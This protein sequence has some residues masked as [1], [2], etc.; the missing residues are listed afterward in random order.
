MRLIFK[1]LLFPLMLKQ[2]LLRPVSKNL[3][4]WRTRFEMP[5]TFS[6]VVERLF[7]FAFRQHGIYR[8]LEGIF[9]FVVTHCKT[10]SLGQFSVLRLEESLCHSFDHVLQLPLL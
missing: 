2:T 3:G 6:E 9:E 7:H 5:I 4:Q 1:A 8:D 10:L